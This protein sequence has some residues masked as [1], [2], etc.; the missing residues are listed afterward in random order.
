MLLTHPFYK[1]FLPKGVEIAD[2]T[3]VA[4]CITC[5]SRP[6]KEAVDEMRHIAA[7][8]GGKKDVREQ[9]EMEKQ[10]EQ[11]GMYGGV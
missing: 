7:E 6:S 9:T 10:M 1:T 4:Q 3:K 8:N 11:T 2:P 5:L